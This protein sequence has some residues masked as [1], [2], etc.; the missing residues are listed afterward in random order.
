MASFLGTRALDLRLHPVDPH[1]C[2][3]QDP[4]LDDLHLSANIATPEIPSLPHKRGPPMRRG[5]VLNLRMDA[6]W[7]RDMHPTPT[8][9]LLHPKVDVIVRD[10]TRP[11]QLNRVFMACSPPHSH[12]PGLR[13]C[14]IQLWQHL[15]TERPNHSPLLIPQVHQVETHRRFH[16]GPTLRCSRTF[17]QLC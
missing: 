7:H 8:D 6:V 11:P 4:S 3:P 12:R 13:I 16:K 2:P 14:R 17:G 9:G 1:R 5:L 15:S 10:R